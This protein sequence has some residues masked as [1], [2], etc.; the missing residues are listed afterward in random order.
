MVFC[1]VWKTYYYEIPHGFYV[2]NLPNIYMLSIIVH[3]VLASR[4]ILLLE[5]LFAY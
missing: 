4:E 3:V 1:V 5:L 2:L